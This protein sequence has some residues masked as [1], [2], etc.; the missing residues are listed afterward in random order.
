MAVVVK[1]WAWLQNLEETGLA[2][3][4]RH[5]LYLFPVLE[6]LH[7]MALS[8]VFGTVMIV[9]LRLLGVASV[10][11]P[12]SRMAAELLRIT[13]VAFALAAVTGALMFVTNARVYA[14]NTSFRIKMV[15]LALAG[16]NMAVFHL[17]VGSTV[18]SW[19]KAVTA[20]RLGKLA[21]ILSLTLWVAVICTGRVVG[22][23]TTGAHARQAA[24]PALNF[25]D[26]L[27]G[28]RA[29]TPDLAVTQ[30]AVG[31]VGPSQPERDRAP[32]RAATE[33]GGNRIAAPVGEGVAAKAKGG[34]TVPAGGPGLREEPPSS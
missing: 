24:P 15:L 21:A 23:T 3:S 28:G 13:W 11:R 10:R 31:R 22:F 4:I 29:S 27:V 9:D 34:P 5:S 17:T 33:E 32:I 14:D 20:P 19:D 6:S 30:P 7:V 26:F 1:T 16:L 25:D 18:T 12:F 2:S 8:L